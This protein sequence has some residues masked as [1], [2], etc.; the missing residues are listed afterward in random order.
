MGFGGKTYDTPSDYSVDRQEK[1]HI[2]HD[3]DALPS[4]KPP[5]R[6]EQLVDAGCTSGSLLA[7]GLV[8]QPSSTAREKSI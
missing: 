8:R 7:C 4:A 1:T 2:V 3:T 5:Q 6:T